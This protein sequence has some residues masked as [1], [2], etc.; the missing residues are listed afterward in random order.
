MKQVI[1]L[2]IIILFAFASFAED[3]NFPLTCGSLTRCSNASFSSIFS[4]S[5][6][7]T[8]INVTGV[9]T[10]SIKYPNGSDYSFPDTTNLSGYAQYNFGSNNF[11]GSG[12][13]TATMINS[14]SGTNY[15]I[16]DSVLSQIRLNNVGV[17]AQPGLYM[18]GGSSFGFTNDNTDFNGNS[19]IIHNFNSNNAI[20]IKRT[21]TG[22]GGF[23]KCQDSG[24]RN[25][26]VTDNLGG[27][28][29][30]STINASSIISRMNKICNETA[31]FTLQELNATG[32][33]WVGVATTDLNASGF[34]INN[35][36]NIT[37]TGIITGGYFSATRNDGNPVATFTQS[38]GWNGANY[39]LTTVGYANLGGFRVNGLDYGNSIYQANSLD[40]G[41]T[42]NDN[43]ALT[44]QGYP[45][46]P[47]YAVFRNGGVGLGTI[48]TSAPI[49]KDGL[50]T[51][52]IMS[53][54]NNIVNVTG[55]VI[56]KNITTP[57][58][59]ADTVD[60]GTAITYDSYLNNLGW[61]TEY[62]NGGYTGFTVLD[63]QG[64]RSYSTN[65]GGYDFFL[66]LAQT[67]PTYS[68]FNSNIQFTTVPGSAGIHLGSGYA[69]YGDGSTLTGVLKNPLTEDLDAS[70]YDIMF[71]NGGRITD[72][73]QTSIDPYNRKLYASDGATVVLDWTD[74]A[75]NPTFAPQVDFT[76]GLTV[77]TGSEMEFGSGAYISDSSYKS[78]DPYNRKL[79]A[80]DGSTV[81]LDWSGLNPDFQSLQLYN[82]GSISGDL[83]PSTKSIDVGARQLTASDGSTVS[84][85]WSSG[86]STE[87]SAGVDDT[88]DD[89]VDTQITFTN[90]L[91]TAISTAY[92]D[93]LLTNISY[94]GT[95]YV[96]VLTPITAQ[97]TEEGLKQYPNQTRESGKLLTIYRISDL[98]K[99]NYTSCIITE[100]LSQWNPVNKTVTISVPINTTVYVNVSAI[101]KIPKP[102]YVNKTIPSTTSY[103]WNGT[104]SV[105]IITNATTIR[106]L[107]DGVYF[108]KTDG[109]WYQITFTP[110]QVIQPSVKYVNTTKEIM[111]NTKGREVKTYNRNCVNNLLITDKEKTIQSLKSQLA[112]ANTNLAN[113]QTKVDKICASTALSGVC[114]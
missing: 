17:S 81:I 71:A 6:N 72:G 106:I 105:K 94:Q 91:A 75:S 107:Q 88:Y 111:E 47:N 43:Y 93:S 112:T 13:I 12:N 92:D 84:L 34:N 38:G 70:T 11:N 69:Y 50:F 74:S 36:T 20:L 99:F 63:G 101:T 83:D 28:F 68:F 100:N 73:S 95:D 18:S 49:S 55:A 86:L 19:N 67:N 87:G 76:S 22:T 3:Y 53:I 10:P 82:V 58:I 57:L 46:Y 66:D 14:K 37:A 25:L 32:G 44:V 77:V 5:V 21:S 51:N 65:R 104:D 24:G 109:Q 61:L 26:M 40:M 45:S 1:W 108:N 23:F 102:I 80:S 79:Y 64:F 54:K 89:G 97:F 110:T 56:A 78:I 35:A 103:N 27:I 90:G 85:D 9:Y 96:N 16:L 114:K 113:I 41:I 52:A 62:S 33:G 2:V 98:I 31:C 15:V 4:S 29:S 42:T 60:L 7:G 39:A 48:N 30:N 59:R 8:T